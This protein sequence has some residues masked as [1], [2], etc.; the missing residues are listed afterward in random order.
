MH[1][2]VCRVPG[3]YCPALVTLGTQTNPT[4]PMPPQPAQTRPIPPGG[5]W[6]GPGKL[7]GSLKRR[8]AATASTEIAV[9]LLP[10]SIG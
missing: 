4:R 8:T 2:C 10:G 5:Q 9:P 1:V 7:P 3:S 6:W